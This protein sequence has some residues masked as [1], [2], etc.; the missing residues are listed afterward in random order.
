MA[1]RNMVLAAVFLLFST[2]GA[3]QAAAEGQCAKLLTTVCNDCHNTDRV[4]NAMG[5]TPERMKGLIDWM[6]SNGA[7]LE[8]EEKVLLVNCLSEPYEEAK[9]VCG[10]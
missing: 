8:S 3:V 9:K 10:K 7:E 1:K 6:I 2:L 5:G 4:C